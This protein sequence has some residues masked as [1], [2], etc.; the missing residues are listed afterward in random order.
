MLED[1]N[2]LVFMEGIKTVE[3]LCL[4]MGKNI[5]QQKLKGFI[6]LLADKYKETKTA[7]VQAVNKSIST[8]IKK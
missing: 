4:L 6:S 3:N 2:A 8:M 5:K 1:S 7:P